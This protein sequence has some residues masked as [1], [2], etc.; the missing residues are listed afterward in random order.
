[1]QVRVLLGE[2]RKRR[3][4]RDNFEI[5]EGGKIKKK[6]RKKNCSQAKLCEAR[7]HYRSATKYRIYLPCIAQ[8][9]KRDNPGAGIITS[10][11]R[12]ICISCLTYRY[13]RDISRKDAHKGRVAG[14]MT[15]RE[16]ATLYASRRRSIYYLPLPPEGNSLGSDCDD[17][18]CLVPRAMTDTELNDRECT[19][20]IRAA[21]IIVSRDTGIFVRGRRSAH[22]TC[23]SRIAFYYEARKVSIKAI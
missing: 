10:Y 4:K 9:I 13:T 21:L 1:M 18:L 16:R 20:E 5:Y 7:I 12:V 23:V 19:A 3:Q 6:K 17:Y 15:S 14:S 2:S 22:S 8:D 11:V